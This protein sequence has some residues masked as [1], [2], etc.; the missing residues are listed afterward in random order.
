MAYYH[1]LLNP[2]A[3]HNG[4]EEV[5]KNLLSI[6]DG[7]NLTFTDVTA[8]KEENDLQNL[9]SAL[10]PE[11]K[12]VI[13]GGDGTLNRFV[14]AVDCDNIA[15]EIY[16]FAAG[17]GNDFYA[18]LKAHADEYFPESEKSAIGENSLLKINKFIRNLPQVTVN[19]KSYKFINGIGYG[20]DGYCCE[21][22]DKLKAAGKKVNYT[23]IAIKGL[24]FH[25]KPRAAKVWVDGKEYEFKKVWIAPTMNG[26]CYGG[27]MIPT[28]NQNRAAKDKLSLCVM[29]GKGKLKTL[30]AF[31]KIFTGEHVKKEKMVK[32]LEGKSITVKFA[33]PCALQIDGETI[34]N[35][36]EYSC[37]LAEA[38]EK[39]LAA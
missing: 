2:F 29:Y 24:L 25:F 37:T 23:S 6:L 27:G 35:V 39:A 21:V 11:T 20:I 26:R 12:L 4:V 10:E 19:G 13:A 14:N 5:K 7:N 9:V 28:P 18:D 32:I 22:G 3:G 30:M 34:L 1:V 16:L 31:P 15:N 8:L 33:K 36:S 38:A 17:S